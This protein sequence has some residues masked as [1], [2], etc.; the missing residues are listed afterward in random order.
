MDVIEHIAAHIEHTQMVQVLQ[1]I[2]VEQLEASVAARGCYGVMDAHMKVNLRSRYSSTV[3]DV[4]AALES[5][6]RLF[7][8]RFSSR[9]A[10]SES[11]RIEFSALLFRLSISSCKRGIYR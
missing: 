10:G 4:K 1:C 5:R 11:T 6:V 3:S 9:R 2:E 7:L 8:A